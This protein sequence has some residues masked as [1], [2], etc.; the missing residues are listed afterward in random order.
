MSSCV[1]RTLQSLRCL[2][3]QPSAIQSEVSPHFLGVEA[4][5]GDKRGVGGAKAEPPMDF[6]SKTHLEDHRQDHKRHSQSHRLYTKC[7]LQFVKNVT[8]FS[9]EDSSPLLNG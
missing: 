6:G 1:P 9:E 7:F 4:Q 5:G 3:T 8:S 2:S